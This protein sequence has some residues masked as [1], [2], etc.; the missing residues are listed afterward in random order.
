M[1]AKPATA[2]GAAAPAPKSK[3][4]IFIIAGVVIALAAGGGYFYWSQKKAAEAAEHEAGDKP[5]KDSAKSAPIF[6]PLD[7]FTVN[8]A[9]T[10]AER[11]A[12]IAVTF[13]LRDAKDSE[14]IKV[15]MPAI[16]H[17]LLKVISSKDSKEI[18]TVDGKD[19]LAQEIAIA[20]G[21]ALGWVPEDTDGDEKEAS[22]EKEGKEGKD[23][24]S[25]KAN[26]NK[27]QKKK[28]VALNPIEQVH[29]SQFIIQ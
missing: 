16:R 26:K 11:M 7:P 21:E 20:A 18:L 24:K 28:P 22:D 13:K 12:Q 29:F 25:S 3:K 4:L 2:D 6:V 27:K 8:L 17:N 10:L 23:S 15:F 14:S 5:A 1:S 19:K 9:D